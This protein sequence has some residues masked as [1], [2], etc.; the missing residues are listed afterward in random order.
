VSVRLPA[1][2]LALTVAPNNSFKRTAG[3]GLCSSHR[4]RPAAA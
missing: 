4:S 3:C 1:W 2:Q